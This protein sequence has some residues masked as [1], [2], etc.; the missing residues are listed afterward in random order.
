M[1]K[2]IQDLEVNRR[3]LQDMVKVLTKDKGKLEKVVEEQKTELAEA[4]D[5]KEK[6]LFNLKLKDSGEC[7]NGCHRY[8]KSMDDVVAACSKHRN[9]VSALKEVAED[10][11]KKNIK[12]KKYNSELEDKV[13]TLDED[14]DHSIR[15][16]RNLQDEK[17]ELI[18]KLN[19]C[20]D[21][22]AANEVHVK[23]LDH[24]NL[25]Y[26]KKIAF[27]KDKLGKS[28]KE[29][30]D[31]K[32]KQKMKSEELESKITVLEANASNAGI[33]KISDN[34]NESPEM[35]ELNVIIKS[36]QVDINAIE[37]KNHDLADELEIKT[38]EV[39]ALEESIK[40][41]N[42][43]KCSSSSLEEE[44]KLSEFFKCNECEES[45]QTKKDLK[46]HT[47]CIHEKIKKKE[48]LKSKLYRSEQSLN[49]RRLQLSSSIF[50]LKKKE[51][52]EK[53]KCRCRGRA[54]C[55]IH[56][57]KHNFR[58]SQSEEFY[59]RL[60]SLSDAS[61]LCDQCDS[62]SPTNS[63]SRNHRQCHEHANLP[64]ERD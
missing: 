16:I 14:T 24:D 19:V 23:Q 37:Q 44:L 39:K 58:K 36:L 21:S 1:E 45:F 22:L 49:E 27:L 29:N 64:G 60:K 40:S 18:V 20:K 30:Q 53:P 10:L 50:N 48:I 42:V 54:F 51:S 63:G 34:D 33:K 26:E 15:I 61:S 5:E 28:L 13:E 47:N 56:H 17:H 3:L 6:A 12:L 62:I 8:N 31:S 41:T 4:L 9:A 52:L 35:V 57:D 2:R 32:I 55:W 46:I 7:K 43:L 59:E 25:D 38:E 11:K